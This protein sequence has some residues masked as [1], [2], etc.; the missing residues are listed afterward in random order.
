MGFS[1][2]G[3]F[4]LMAAKDQNLSEKIDHLVLVVPWIPSYL[5]LI[6]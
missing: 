5:L 3:S 4:A 6:S 1:A 2:G